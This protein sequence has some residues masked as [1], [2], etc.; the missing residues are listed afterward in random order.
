MDL[1]Y[2]LADVLVALSDV[3]ASGC[4]RV[5]AEQGNALV[6]LREGQ[7]YAATVP[8]ERTPLGARLIEAG[9]V[10]EADLAAALDAQN[11]ELLVAWRLGELVVHLG[12]AE[13]SGVERVVAAL[14]LEDLDV[15][16]SWT[17]VGVRF[18]PG[19]K[20]R[21]DVTPAVTVPALLDPTWRTLPDPPEFMPV[22]FVLEPAEPERTLE[23]ALFGALAAQTASFSP[24]PLPQVVDTADVLR[25]IRGLNQFHDDNDD[26]D[27]H[28]RPRPPGLRQRRARPRAA[29]RDG[30]VVRAGP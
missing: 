20:T 19:V 15:L 21:Q 27:D 14:L 1:T 3:R 16:L 25:Q 4:L 13:R 24:A 5:D 23:Y 29:G 8:T 18:R 6:F 7:V 10:D 12:M 26:P 30:A 2:S 17:V 9:L 11:E 22:P 28:R